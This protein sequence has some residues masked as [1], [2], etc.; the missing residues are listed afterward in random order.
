MT[1]KHHDAAL[2]PVRQII[3][4]ASQRLGIGSKDLALAL[5]FK[6]ISAVSML[7]S[8]TMKLPMDK[9]QITAEVLQLDVIYLARCVDHEAGTN[10]MTILEKIAARSAL[11]ESEAWLISRLRETSGSQDVDIRRHPERLGAILAAWQAACTEL[12]T[13]GAESVSNLAKS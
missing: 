2:Q 6:T 13:N 1:A 10:L 12:P 9:V 11:T 4:D 8:G 5:G 3:K 7:K